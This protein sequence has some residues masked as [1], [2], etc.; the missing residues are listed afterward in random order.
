MI[1][2][3]SVLFNIAFF[4][5]TAMVAILSTPVLLAPAHWTMPPIRFWA[6]LVVQELRFICGIRLVVTGREHL[7]QQGPALI[8][9][10]H[11]SAFDTVIWL[12][13]VPK[14]A[15]VLKQEL[16]RIPFY[17]FL[18]AKVGM[19][20][21]DRAGGGAAMRHLLKAGKD[22]AAA[23]RQLVI[24]P[25]GTRV[26]PGERVPYQPGIAALASA[27]GLPVIPVATDS[28]VRWGRRAFLKRPGTITISV[29]PPLPAGLPRA[30]LIGELERVIET[31]SDR[32]MAGHPV[33]NPVDDL[34]HAA[35]P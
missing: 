6:W 12:L 4:G 19:I 15:Y 35:V 11:Q 13:L 5:S 30:V 7:P 20:S 1:W 21:V 32:L 31:E 22:A 16:L 33:D 28:G 17:G 24:F 9:A 25:E 3:R 26:A 27:T 29:L 18:V 8:A 14:C 34:P 23:G 2:L 10:K